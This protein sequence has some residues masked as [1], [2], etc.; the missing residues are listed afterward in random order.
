MGGESVFMSA[1]SIYLYVSVLI[2]VVKEIEWC[3]P[4]RNIVPNGTKCP[5]K[6]KEN[7]LKIS[8]G[9]GEKIK[10]KERKKKSFRQLEKKM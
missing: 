1:V 4:V 2:M 5:S 6:K 9:T 10:K 8:I 3:E 7:R